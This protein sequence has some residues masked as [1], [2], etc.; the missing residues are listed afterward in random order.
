M[1]EAQPIWPTVIEPVLDEPA[2]IPDDPLFSSGSQWYLYDTS[3]AVASLNISSIWDEYSGAGVTIGIVDD[4]VEYDHPDLVANS[5]PSMGR[6]FVGHQT[7]TPNDGRPYDNDDRHGTTVAGVAAGSD[8]SVGIVGVAFGAT[9]AGLRIGFNSD[10]G[11][12]QVHAAFIEGKNFDIVN[13][14]WGYG[15]YF[16]DNFNDLNSFGGSAN[17]FAGINDALIDAVSNGRPHETDAGVNLGTIFIVASGNDKLTNYTNLPD[18]NVNYQ[19]FTSSPHTI[20]VGGYIQNGTDANFSTPGAAVLLAGPASGVKSTDRVGNP[21]YNWGGDYVTKSGT[22]Y[23]APAVAGVAALML[24]ANPNL[25][26]RDVQ[27]IFSLSSEFGDPNDADWMINGAGDWNGGGRHVSDELGF[28][29]LDAYNAVRLAETWDIVSTYANLQEA[30]V[31]SGPVNGILD[32]NTISHTITVADQGIDLQHVVL[33]LNLSHFRVGELTVTLTSPDGT[34]SLLI[35]KPGGGSAYASTFIDEFALTSVQ[36]WG[37]D[38]AGDWTVTVTDSDYNGNDTVQHT[39]LWSSFDLTFL[40]NAATADDLYVYTSEYGRFGAET[41]RQTL[42]DAGGYDTLNL[43]TIADGVTIDLTPGAANTLRGNPFNIGSGTVIEKVYGG[44]GADEF[45]GNAAD[46]AL[47]GMRGDDELTGA[48]GNDLLNGGDGYDTAVYAGNIADF[49][50]T[51]NLD[52]SVTIED[53]VGAEGLDTLVGIELVQFADGTYQVGDELDDPEEGKPEVVLPTITHSG[54]SASSEYILGDDGPNVLATGGG[55]WDSLDGG[56][57]DDAY[58]I[59]NPSVSIRDS[60]FQGVDTVYSGA[61]SYNLPNFIENGIMLDN[62]VSLNGSF[63]DNYLEGNDLDNTIQAK[64][65]DDIIN[66]WGGD[67]VITG[68]A[69]NDIIDGGAGQDTAVFNSVLADFLITE[70]ADGT[71][72]VLDL[73]GD[74]GMDRLSHVEFLQFTDQTIAAPDAIAD[75]VSGVDLDPLPHP[76]G[77]T[78]PAPTIAKTPDNFQ[79]VTGTSGADVLWGGGGHSDALRG[80]EG[81]DTYI[82]TNPNTSVREY[83]NDGD[84]TVVTYA[85]SFSTQ[86]SIETVYMMWGA[87][88]FSGGDEGSTVY[89]NDHVNTISARGVDDVVLGYAGDDD[90]DGGDGDDVLSGGAGNDQIDGGDGDDK[91]SYAGAKADYTIVENADQSVTVTDNV[92]VEGTDTLLNIETLIFADGIYPVGGGGGGGGGGGSNPG[93]PKPPVV[94]P[95]ETHSGTGAGGETISGDRGDNVLNGHGGSWDTLEGFGGNDSYIIESA[96]SLSLK[97][98]TLDGTDTIYTDIA[99]TFMPLHFEIAYL[100][101]N[102]GNISGTDFSNYIEGN[103]KANAI[104]GLDDVDELLGW[105]G[106]DM[107]TG[108][109]DNDFINGGDGA[110]TAVF[111]SNLANYLIEDQGDGSFTVLDLVGK[112]GTDRLVQVEFLQFADQTIA[113]PVS[114]AGSSAPAPLSAL[115]G[116]NDILPPSASLSGTLESYENI[117]GTS[118]NDVLTAGGG[119]LDTL[120][121]QGGDDSYIIESESTRIKEYY[122]GGNDTVYSYASTLSTSANVETFYMMY[123]ALSLTGSGHD[124]TIFGN[125][126]DNTINGRNGNDILAGYEGDDVLIGGGGNDTAVFQGNLADFDIVW[127]GGTDLEVSDIAGGG[128]G[129]DSLTQIEFLEFNDGTV[130]AAG[131]FV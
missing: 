3:S 21:G 97:E 48:G 12:S 79:T 11:T 106:D 36:Y 60:S 50:I 81:D 99:T 15:G 43:A 110:D 66:A 30:T 14:S 129:T 8:N 35:N 49:G 128:Q 46:N 44:D 88:S 101:D 52:A 56:G 70:H 41:A 131:F 119:Y 28:G 100:L 37:E 90:L 19:G 107:L 87:I 54:T 25:G 5:D 117:N 26:Y 53:L 86:E 75:P 24:E 108:G 98:S 102:A 16:Y 78:A 9:V 89:G 73:V 118:G 68:G 20:A 80:N 39:G 105:G 109:K 127:L 85:S 93:N 91:A 42:N 23:A 124:N 95:A 55:V 69:L 18:Q 77:Y 92:G 111:A 113:A 62:A 63:L 82:I 121:G 64:D 94:L 71:L 114:G 84:D 4:G 112:E 104:Y 58:I 31:S 59:Y 103:D 115:P 45:T 125:K 6:N 67:D 122:N 29:T 2:Y 7:T 116:Q 72:S 27:E 13:N 126:H 1:I 10:H 17:P 47:Y 120:I 32:R 33:G 40:G 65:G 61:F 96:E 123:G 76:T 38:I 51:L 130:D 34:T 83:N 74:L 57:G 22:S